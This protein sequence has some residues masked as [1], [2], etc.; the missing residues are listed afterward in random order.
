MANRRTKRR[1]ILISVKMRIRKIKQVRNLIDS[2]NEQNKNVCFYLIWFSW[3]VEY[4]I[5]NLF[6]NWKVITTWNLD[7][8]LWFLEGYSEK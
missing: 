3:G 4:W 1:F 2:I 5:I 6:Q 8:I 7:H